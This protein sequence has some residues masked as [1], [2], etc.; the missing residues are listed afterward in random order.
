MGGC[1]LLCR[2]SDYVPKYILI[3]VEDISAL[4]SMTTQSD[5]RCKEDGGQEQ[6]WIRYS[7]Y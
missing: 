7:N 3:S 4:R 6:W 1:R 2:G 5:Y